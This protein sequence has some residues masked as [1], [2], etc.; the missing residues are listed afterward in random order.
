MVIDSQIH[1]WAPN[2]RSRPWADGWQHT[3]PPPEMT[4]ETV[5]REMDDAGVDRCVLVPPSWEGDRNDFALRACEL[6]PDRFGVMGRI[7]VDEPERSSELLED[8]L[9][10]PGMLGVR[11]VFYRR[12][13]E[14]LGNGVADWFWPLAERLGIPVMVF[15]PGLDALI[16][17]VADRHPALMLVV[18]H[19]NIAPTT[20]FTVEEG[21]ASV[22]SRI[23]GT[24]ALATR[25]NVM[26]K[27][28]GLPRNA[29]DPY[30]FESVHPVV[31]AAFEAF[32]VERCFW[33]SDLTQ[34][35]CSY[36]ESVRFIGEIGSLGASDLTGLMGE[37]LRASL[38]WH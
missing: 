6:Y 29:S 8:W 12:T 4:P 17:E 11:L 26:V 28:S 23:A 14:W 20:K 1:V 2:T 25:S 34:L 32:G 31:R 22:T 33:G 27:I 38:G 37:S 3:E 19:V 24:L 35:T 21:P 10:L 16:G 5:L 30:P 18:D 15:A 13:G 36:G 9:S 7:L